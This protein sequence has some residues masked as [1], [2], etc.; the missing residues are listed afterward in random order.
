MIANDPERDYEILC[1]AVH[2]IRR[3]KAQEEQRSPPD[4]E[5]TNIASSS[6]TVQ[7]CSVKETGGT[8]Q[9]SVQEAVLLVQDGLSQQR[10][11]RTGVNL[12][13]KFEMSRRCA[14]TRTTI[15]SF[16]TGALQRQCLRDATRGRCESGARVRS[17]PGSATKAGKTPLVPWNGSINR[18]ELVER[19]PPTKSHLVKRCSDGCRRLLSIVTRVAGVRRTAGR[20][21]MAPRYP[22][23]MQRSH[24]TTWL[25]AR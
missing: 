5:V 10:N 17:A 6:A 15:R 11:S 20:V 13:D 8:H 21:E 23:G 9:R 4:P 3:T 1:A 14:P 25:R 18:A 16:C 12:D 22:A 24:S 7:Q 19:C 2:W